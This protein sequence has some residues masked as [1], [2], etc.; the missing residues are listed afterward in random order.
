MTEHLHA[1]PV[2]IM[3]D[4]KQLATLSGALVVLCVWPFEKKSAREIAARAAGDDAERFTDEIGRLTR[5]HFKSCGLWSPNLAWTQELMSLRA[6]TATHASFG[7]V[8]AAIAITA[9]RTCALEFSDRWWEFC[10]VAPGGLEKYG[11]V[12]T[13][14]LALADLIFTERLR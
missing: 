3:L 11:V 9:L 14:L 1:E 2:E 8:Q 7:R 6:K 5:E 12:S 13:D 4:G 10:V